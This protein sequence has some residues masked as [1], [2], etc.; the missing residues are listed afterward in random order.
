M[1]NEGWKNYVTENSGDKAAGKIV[2]KL[3]TD[4]TDPDYLYSRIHHFLGKYES[5][6][7]LTI[8]Q[9]FRFINGKLVEWRAT[10]EYKDG[11][12]VNPK[13]GRRVPV[14]NETSFEWGPKPVVEA[15]PVPPVV[16]EA[17]VA[18]TVT[19]EPTTVPPVAAPESHAPDYLDEAAL[20]LVA[21]QLTNDQQ[22]LEVA[23]K[24]KTEAEA[25]LAKNPFFKGK[26]NDHGRS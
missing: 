18:T 25:A 10:P 4:K 7:K 23:R 20:N 2:V 22:V 12:W 13:T 14:I 8:F 11:T 19:V 15:A 3:P 26:W 9:N 16:A 6:V 21:V 24:S 1:H 5:I 17:T